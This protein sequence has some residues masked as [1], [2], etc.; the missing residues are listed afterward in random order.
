ME[1]YISWKIKL[2]SNVLW[3]TK[4]EFHLSFASFLLDELIKPSNTCS[5]G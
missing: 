4:G 2:F 1:D 5:N 3:V